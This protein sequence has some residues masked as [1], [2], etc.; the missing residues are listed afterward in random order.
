[1]SCS[2]DYEAPAFAHEKMVKA[3]KF[4]RCGDCTRS[5]LPGEVYQRINGKWDGILCRV[6]I[7][8]DCRLIRDMIDC[9]IAVAPAD[10]DCECAPGIGEL[11]TWLAEWEREHG[12]G[13]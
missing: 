2:C 12:E 6:Q 8:A 10:S 1:M 4:H 9:W 5:I 13:R 3:R 11:L 7:C